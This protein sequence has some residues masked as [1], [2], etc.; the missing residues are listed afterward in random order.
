M[1][2]L[3]APAVG[4]GRLPRSTPA[5][6]A[7]LGLALLQALLLG[8]LAAPAGAAE[9]SCSAS[10][11][12]RADGGAPSSF[13]VGCSGVTT[14]SGTVYVDADEGRR[15]SF[16]QGALASASATAGA[17]ALHASANARASAS[18]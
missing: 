3:H 13:G 1:A 7:A 17:G 14:S 16:S 15:Y 11:S 18:R 5:R 12:T 2:P 8:A 6:P 10:G 4:C 9:G